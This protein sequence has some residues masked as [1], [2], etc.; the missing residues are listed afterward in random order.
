MPETRN[1]P[2]F[3]KPLVQSKVNYLKI[4]NYLNSSIQNSTLLIAACL[5]NLQQAAAKFTSI[6]FMH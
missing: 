2:K 3:L 5:I 1:S 6:Y 4:D